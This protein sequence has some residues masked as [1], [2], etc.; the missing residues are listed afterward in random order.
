[1]QPYDHQSDAP[2]VISAYGHNYYHK[3]YVQWLRHQTNDGWYSGWRSGAF[4]TTAVIASG[5]FMH[6]LLHHFFGWT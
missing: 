1:M 4:W 5:V 6:Y 2:Y 3:S